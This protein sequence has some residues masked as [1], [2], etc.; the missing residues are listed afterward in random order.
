[1]TE[2]AFLSRLLSVDEVA[3]FLNVS[4]V[5][6]YRLAE[7]GLLRVH[8]VARTLRFSRDAVTSYLDREDNHAPYGGPQD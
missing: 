6:V 3:S 2:T 5:T 8:R 1:M 4:R 7:R